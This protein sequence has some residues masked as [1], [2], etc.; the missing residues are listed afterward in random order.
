MALLPEAVQISEEI[1]A[2]VRKHNERK[3]LTD[4]QLHTIIAY[5]KQL[6]LLWGILTMRPNA[7][8]PLSRVLT[9]D[10]PSFN[11]SGGRSRNSEG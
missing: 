10:G 6:H 2:L 4:L 3:E 5:R 9:N 8:N 11:G 1:L 7:Q